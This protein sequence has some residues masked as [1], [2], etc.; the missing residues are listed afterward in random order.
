MIDETI[1]K[2]LEEDVC[3]IRG[4]DRSMLISADKGKFV[5]KVIPGEDCSNNVG[6]IHGGFLLAAADIA[7]SG[8]C[9]TYGE[10]VLP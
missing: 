9:D 5:M 4:F 2:Y 8:A 7:A 3:D 1:M 10:N 6:T